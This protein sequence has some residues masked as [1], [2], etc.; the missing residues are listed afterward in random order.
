MITIQTIDK[1]YELALSALASLPINKATEK[2]VMELIYLHDNL[3][4]KI[5]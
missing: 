2:W 5:K 3:R 4:K 1:R